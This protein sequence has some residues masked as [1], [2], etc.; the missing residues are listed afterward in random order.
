MQIRSHLVM[1]G[2]SHFTWENFNT[3]LSLHTAYFICL[4]RMKGGR[5]SIIP[6]HLKERELS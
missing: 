1:Q 5:P 4:C 6:V 2:Y 3:D